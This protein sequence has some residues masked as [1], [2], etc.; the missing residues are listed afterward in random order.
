M[1]SIACPVCGYHQFRHAFHARD[2]FVSGKDFPVNA[3]IQCGMLITG[4]MPPDSE[5]DNFYKS[6][7]YISHSDTR[8]GLINQAYHLIRKFMLS[9]KYQLIRSQTKRQKGALLDIGAGTG[10]FLDYMQKKGWQV[11][12]TEKSIEAKQYASGKWNIT[13]LP[14]EQLFEFRPASFDVITL[15]HVMEHL[16]NLNQHWQVISKILKPD[17]ILVIALPN[18]K[19]RDA[20]HYGPYWAAWDVPRHRWHFAPRHIRELGRREGFRLKTIC[21]MPF[22]AF[23]ISI[24]SEQ[25]KKTTF[26]LLSGFFYGKISWLA[27]L[28]NKKRCSSL[29]YVFR[30]SG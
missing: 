16:P 18:P 3:C 11:T 24:M 10:Y 23:Y 12:G 6:D 1:N 14:E 9:R 26:P 19:S 8:H 7:A 25:Y 5:L 4:A 22:D 20:R 30:K 29:I 27:S 2:H 17:G 13:L 15:W 28:F 21:R